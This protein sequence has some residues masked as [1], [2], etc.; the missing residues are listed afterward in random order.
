[1]TNGHS[2]GL[3][4][5]LTTHSNV[6]N[7]EGPSVRPKRLRQTTLKAERRLRIGTRPPV[8]TEKLILS[9]PEINHFFTDL[10][11]QA[12]VDGVPLK[13]QLP[14][15]DPA[16]P[17]LETEKRRSIRAV[18]YQTYLLANCSTPY[19]STRVELHH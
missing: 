16:L 18:D 3:Y 5:R 14:V 2:R 12:N 4:H 15:M 11:E 10:S 9:H 1:M 17:I 13:S 6:R 7:N 19:D 8:L